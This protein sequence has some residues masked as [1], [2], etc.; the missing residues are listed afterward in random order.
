MHLTGTGRRRRPFF[1]LSRS[2][3]HPARPPP[4]PPLPRPRLRR[5]APPRAHGAQ[6][7]LRRRREDPAPPLLARLRHPLRPP[8][9]AAAAQRLAAAA[10]AAGSTAAYQGGEG[11]GGWVSRLVDPASRL[12]AGGASRLFS[13]VFRK[14]LAPA[15][16]PAPAPAALEPPASA[17]P[18]E[19]RLPPARFP[20]D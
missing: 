2:P 12:I 7:V 20:V 5:P 14:R 18:G 19:H 3:A 13:T 8:P 4:H 9:A 6:L 15:P 10:A 11:G 16:A 17:T 1:P